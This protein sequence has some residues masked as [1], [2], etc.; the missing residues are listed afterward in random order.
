VKTIINISLFVFI[1]GS[2]MAQSFELIPNTTD[3]INYVDVSGRKQ[4]KWI[5]FG[6]HKPSG[7]YAINQKVEEGLYKENRK[8]GQW[9][10]YFCNGNPKNKVTFANGRPDG[11]AIL[12]FENGKVSEEGEWKNNRWVGNLTQYYEN[13]Q[14]QHDFKFNANGKREGE[15]VYKYENGQTAVKG[16][17]VNGKETGVIKEFHETGELKAEKTFNEGNVDVASIKFFDPKKEF[18]KKTETLKNEPK[19][20]VK[21]DEK[22]NSANKAPLVLNGQHKLYNGNKQITKDGAFKENR[23]ISGKAYIYNENGILTRVAIYKNG[24]YAGDGVLEN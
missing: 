6:K 24:I 1:T 3:T 23:L 7:C 10:E 11:Y 4:G 13:G 14:V 8:I 15:Q 5:L 22:P 20:T 18:V 21:A 19:I 9:S 12:Y 2:L 16:N 17:F